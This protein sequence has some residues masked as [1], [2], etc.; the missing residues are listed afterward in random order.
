[1]KIKKLLNIQSGFSL[2]ELLVVVAII[3]ILA[4]VAIPA[5]NAY[6]ENAKVG[7]ISSSL[8]QITKAFNTCLAVG[9]PASTCA[10][11]VNVNGT[12]RLDM[13]TQGMADR[14]AGQNCFFIT[15]GTTIASGMN[16]AGLTGCVELTD[17]GVVTSITDNAGIVS[18]KQGFCMTGV[19]DITP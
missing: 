19:C 7:V 10:G 1:M 3:G 14:V 13:A 15:Y 17:V 16:M 6:Q 11:N 4:A 18:K 9:N 5:Y 2:I 12:V 8:S